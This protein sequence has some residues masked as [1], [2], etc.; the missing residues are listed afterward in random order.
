MTPGSGERLDR[1]LVIAGL[2]SSRRAAQELIAGGLVRVNGVRCRKAHAI[3]DN[4]RV[5]V[6]G[7]LRAGTIEPN[8]AIALE[9]IHIDDA[10]IIVNKPGS[11]PCHPLRAGERDTVMNAVVAQFPETA[12]AGDSP[13]EGGLVHRLDN[14][15]SGALMV[16][17]NREAFAV[18][19]D[20]IRSGK[21][22]RTYLA[23]VNGAMNS[24]MELSAPIAHGRNPRKMTPG[25]SQST[26]RKR[27]GRSATTIV[28]PL[29][30]AGRWTLVRAMPRT[31]SRHQ[32]RVHLA[33]AGF[34]I[35]G[36]ALYGGPEAGL[37]K[38]RFWLHLSELELDSPVGGHIKVTAPLPADLQKT[39]R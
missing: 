24:G 1:Y 30:R 8:P 29:Q 12:T 34:P 2:A 35:V 11:M 21:I 16:A 18:L 6:V 38:D 13:R 32:I 4:D 22:G 25:E 26:K 20:A 3:G 36:D 27:A 14:G 39:M 23:M 31:G 17:R 9:N 19:R 33:D 10:L 37:P 5:E 7:E 15:T 28:E